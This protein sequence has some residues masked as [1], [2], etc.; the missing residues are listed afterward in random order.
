M[1]KNRGEYDFSDIDWQ[2]DE[3]NKRDAKIVLAMGQKVPRWPECFAPQWATSPDTRKEGLLSFERQVVERY[4]DHPEVVMW[5]VEN[6]PFLEFGNCPDFDISLLDE[7]IALV[8]SID[9]SKPVLT[10]A[11]GE[12]SFW[13]RPADRGDMFGTTLYRDL[14]SKKLGR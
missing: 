4:K 13:V 12:F 5:Q 3:A 1:E 2:L 9:V 6:E 7:E 14:W 8:K 10:T 11:N